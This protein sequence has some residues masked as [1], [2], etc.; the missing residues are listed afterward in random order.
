MNMKTLSQNRHLGRIPH[1]ELVRLLATNPRNQALADEFMSRYESVIRNA[2]TQAI[3]KRKEKAYYEA[4]QA[5]IEDMVN[6]TYC[7]L[8]QNDSQVLRAFAG[9]HANSIFAYLRTIAFSVVSNQFRARRRHHAPEQLQSLDAIEEKYNNAWP[10]DGA[11]ISQSAWS[12]HQTAECKSIEEMIRANFRSA[13]RAANVNR[14]FIIFKLHF[15]Y[16][17]HSHEI[18]RIKGMGLSEH[19]VG[20]TADRIRQC[21]RK[22]QNE[23]SALN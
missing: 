6:E 3:Y 14:N 2:V 8:F 4:I 11:A 12:G 21:L 15:L 1:D 13:F 20:N 19:G 9:R 17:Y 10:E 22:R 18:A 7:R 16:G 5:L 23:L